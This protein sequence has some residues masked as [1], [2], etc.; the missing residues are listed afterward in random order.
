MHL[1]P[2]NAVV[3]RLNNE[4]ANNIRLGKNGRALSLLNKALIELQFHSINQS[5]PSICITPVEDQEEQP[6]ESY[7]EGMKTLSEP[8]IIDPSEAETQL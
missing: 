4:A 3:A 1:N 8:L 5:F 7:D 6:P 2:V